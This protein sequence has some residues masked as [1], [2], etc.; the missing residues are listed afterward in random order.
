MTAV[1]QDLGS[2]TWLPLGAWRIEAR[3]HVMM[4]LRRLFPRSRATRG[5]ITVAHTPEIALELEW[6]LLR[7]PMAMSPADRSRLF[8]EA[9]AYRA[10]QVRIADILSGS[11]SATGDAWREP[12]EPARPYQLQASDLV[13]TTG[14]LLV[15]DV[16]GLGKTFT[17]LL[18]FRHPESTPGLVVAAPHLLRQWREQAARF[19]PLLRTHIVRTTAPYDPREHREMAGYDPDVLLI[20][21][22]KLDAWRYH[23]A[24]K[25]A[26]TIFDEVHELRR[27]ESRKYGAAADVAAD[28]R[29]RVGLTATPV[30]NYGGDIHNILSVLSPGALGSREEFVAEW[31]RYGQN[32]KILVND[33]DALGEYLRAEG[34][35]VR[36]TRRD[37]GRELPAVQRITETIE[38]DRSPLEDVHKAARE[39]ARTILESDD[40]E[41]R[42]VAGG[43]LDMR[44]RHATGVAKAPHIADFVRL[45]LEDERKVVCFLWHHDVYHAVGDRLADLDPVLYTG[46]ESPAAKQR[47]KDR[48]LTDDECRV[49]LMS[50]RA[51]AGL[52]GLQEVCSTA[53]FGELDWS[54]AMHDQC[55]GRFHRDGQQHPVSAYFLLAETGSDPIVA[56]TLGLKRRQ[57]E[58]IES[59]G[60]ELFQP[61]ADTGNYIKRL[62]EA[63][64]SKGA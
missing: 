28:A 47:A 8:D 45:V 16:L 58:G 2:L 55:I 4:R 10:Q 49:M 15:G 13:L 19:F 14:G 34:L 48:F 35:M 63:V 32:G 57:A 29:F 37:V 11:A 23:L 18:T 54:P 53:V 25:V 1:Q 43:E 21:Y 12:A 39:L 41:Q 40:K 50:L 6:L 42:F 60:G 46:R 61:V 7:W 30:F 22:S 5:A 20:T 38:T 24:G 51:G 31:A 62:A 9:E 33:P 56:Q 59:P 26:T 36:R 27:S 44:M 64:L 3:P 52:D 17:G